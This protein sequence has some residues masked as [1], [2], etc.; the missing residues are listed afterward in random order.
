VRWYTVLT[1]IRRSTKWNYKAGY[2]YVLFFCNSEVQCHNSLTLDC[3][4]KCLHRATGYLMSICGDVWI[5]LHSLFY[6][7]ML[8]AKMC[9]QAYSLPLII[10]E[11]DIGTNFPA[12]SVNPLLA[13]AMM[14]TRQRWNGTR[15]PTQS[16]S[17]VASLTLSDWNDSENTETCFRE[18]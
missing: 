1:F 7:C 12:V 4:I 14:K 17:H 10:V 11:L 13:A 9:R 2:C 6:K 15:V 3:E 16:E 5:I 18:K 8:C